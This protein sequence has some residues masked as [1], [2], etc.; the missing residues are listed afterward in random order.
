MA[1]GTSYYQLLSIIDNTEIRS[2][3]PEKNK[4]H[5]I[6]AVILDK[7]SAEKGKKGGYSPP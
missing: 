7:I 1:W 5:G 2:I 3:Q 6:L 4:I